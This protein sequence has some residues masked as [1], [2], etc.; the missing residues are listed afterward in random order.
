MQFR[1]I[2]SKIAFM[3]AV[4]LLMSAIVLV[5]FG[6]VTSQQ[7]H[8]YVSSHV[9]EILEKRIFSNL[10]ALAESQAAVVQSSLQENLDTARTIAKVF[11]V[12]QRE[13]DQNAS[14]LRDTF[15]SILYA[16]LENNPD[17]LGAYSA[18]EPNA[19][20]GQDAK[21]A[22]DYQNGYDD[23]GRFIPYWNRDPNGK[24]ARQ[25]L[26]EYESHE[27]HANGVRKGGWYLGPRETG[28]ESVLDP[29][30]YIVQGKRDWLTT[31]SVPIKKNGTFL[32]VA[33]TDLRLNFLQELAKNVNSK[34]YEGQGDVTIIS[35]DGL[36][37]ANSKDPKA[38][39]DPIKAIFDNSQEIISHVQDGKALTG[40]DKASNMLLAYAPIQLGRTGK[41]W[42]VLIRVPEA[43][44]MTDV[45]NLEE[46]LSSQA[47]QSATW[48]IVVGII[49]S[50]IAMGI[51]WLLAGGIVKPLRKAAEYAETVAGG[52]FSKHLDVQ[53]KDEVGT[54]ADALRSMV[55]SLEAKIMEAEQKGEEALRETEHAKLAMDEAEEARAQAEQAKAEGILAAASKIEGVVEVI[56]SASEELSAQVEQSSRGADQQAQRVS[57]TVSSM[58]EMNNSVL[59]VARNASDAA[60]ACEQ[61]GD[62][63][64][65]GSGVVDQVVKSIKEVQKLSDILKQD[66]T[67]LGEQAEGIGRIL[68]VISDIADQ[69]NL[70]ALNAAIEA[71]R[72][73]EAG[74]GFAVVADE[75]RKL[76]EKTMTAT[77]EVGQAID[78]VQQG[79]RKNISNVDRA[80]SKVEEATALAGE[81]GQALREIVYLVGQVSD[82]VRSMATA[83][84]EQAS[85]SEE[86]NRAI[87]DVSRISSETSD[88]MN[89][90]AQAVV[91]LARQAQELSTLVQEMQAENSNIPGNTS[92]ALPK[93]SKRLALS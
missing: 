10:E 17:F 30:P 20:D 4:C 41:P 24:I 72:A 14:S 42:S 67:T 27:H 13:N 40:E 83:S 8:Q 54:L 16:I 84:E 25:A 69:T 44:A 49:V 3:A 39:G 45:T 60:N 73:G 38:I 90:S 36:V 23:T 70:L 2:K 66:M 80:V 6:L 47:H 1:S 75:V 22:G 5:S 46:A 91:E 19:L 64:K 93:G 78:S 11:E 74:R 79:T 71:A 62:K 61:T 26:V 51:M 56:T 34:L 32:G 87:E 59:E 57:E 29:F 31:L 55:S 63:A 50:I 52:D 85:S 35:Y 92:R 88:A 81:S 15:N 65:Q 37:V 58:E 48:Q 43:I 33:G 77:S 12:L 28:K 18:W 21:Y 89:Q 76:A 9:Y 7:T 68:N 82:Q 86:I 53:Q